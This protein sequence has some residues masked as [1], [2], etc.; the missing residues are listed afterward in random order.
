[1]LDA[2]DVW[3]VRGAGCGV[4]WRVSANT[5]NGVASAVTV[6]VIRSTT[7][8]NNNNTEGTLCSFEFFYLVPVDQFIQTPTL[9]NRTRTLCVPSGHG[10]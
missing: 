7:T 4:R 10:Q 5:W 6:I 3:V 9:A 1:M 2:I 8:N